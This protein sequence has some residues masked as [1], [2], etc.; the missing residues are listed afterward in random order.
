MY[1]SAAALQ[2]RINT[3]NLRRSAPIDGRAQHRPVVN[4]TTP[5]RTTRGLGFKV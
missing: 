4:D 5:A 2:I 3:P 1:I